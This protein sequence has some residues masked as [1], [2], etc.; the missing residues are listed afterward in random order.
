MSKVNITDREC[1]AVIKAYNCLIPDGIVP[2]LDLAAML[3][4]VGSRLISAY[5]EGH[6]MAEALALSPV[7]DRLV[8]D[9]LIKESHQE[10]LYLRSYVN[11]RKVDHM[12]YSIPSP[13]WDLKI[14]EE[15][16]AEI[17]AE[18]FL[19]LKSLP[20]R[21]LFKGGIKTLPPKVLLRE[22]VLEA[23]PAHDPDDYAINIPEM[24]LK[25]SEGA[26]KD[27]A[28]MF[29]PM[30]RE[31]LRDTFNDMFGVDDELSLDDGRTLHR[32]VVDNVTLYES[33]KLEDEDPVDNVS[34]ED[35]ITYDELVELAQHILRHVVT[36]CA[37]VPISTRS[38]TMC[39]L[40][41]SQL[42][43]GQDTVKLI[44][45][46][47]D[48][49]MQG[50]ARMWRE[51]N[52]RIVLEEKE[53]GAL[54][55]VIPEEVVEPEEGPVNPLAYVYIYPTLLRVKSTG[56]GLKYN[57]LAGEISR[58]DQTCLVEQE[59]LKEFQQTFTSYHTNLKYNGIDHEIV[60]DEGNIFVRTLRVIRGTNT[61]QVQMDAP[62]A[63]YFDPNDVGSQ[64]PPVGQTNVSGFLGGTP[65]HYI[66]QQPGARPQMQHTP[67]SLHINDMLAYLTRNIDD[68]KISLKALVE[69]YLR[70][71]I[72][73]EGDTRPTV[74]EL[75][76][77]LET[78]LCPHGDWV[79]LGNI[80][81]FGKMVRLF[82]EDGMKMLSVTTMESPPQLHPNVGVY[83]NSLFSYLATNFVGRRDS[84]ANLVN[85]YVHAKCT[86]PYD[87]IFVKVLL[88][89]IKETICP[90]GGDV[91]TKVIAG[92][93]FTFTVENG[94]DMLEVAAMAQTSHPFNYSPK[95]ASMSPQPK[96]LDGATREKMET[97]YGDVSVFLEHITGS[98]NLVGGSVKDFIRIF[99]ESFLGGLADDIT[100]RLERAVDMY[101]LAQRYSEKDVVVNNKLI[102][103]SQVRERAYLGIKEVEDV[104][105]PMDLETFSTAELHAMLGE[106]SKILATRFKG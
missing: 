11:N 26:Y 83:L 36:E 64:Y 35:T 78:T 102:T 92:A 76:V 50:N 96:P 62:V 80:P 67:V 68:R 30:S 48:V 23:L 41:Y 42:Y 60:N 29:L 72:C 75:M 84:A 73:I 58:T 79:T 87:L 99:S 94:V 51:G 43:L 105:A 44:V 54:L 32:K 24:W 74:A 65:A 63:G 57:L 28:E 33:R 1:Y 40:S 106:V 103:W 14:G 90:A 39:Y 89:A 91:G 49:I 100:Y 4:M 61:S 34:D 53:T 7:L 88:S 18:A 86:N 55:H 2:T 17:M 20:Q 85:T 97:K 77:V 37:D 52:A 12:G 6:L 70:A 66:G 47:V 8:G 45:S 38:A 46:V 101:F 9:K 21:S 82:A 95:V 31:L 13:L 56:L 71:T 81:L 16:D 59:C 27:V 10:V 104:V 22:F 25:H 15:R 93:V 19:S 69:G 5:D 98:L 3:N